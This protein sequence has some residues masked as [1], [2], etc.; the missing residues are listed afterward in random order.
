MQGMAA[1]QQIVGTDRLAQSA[2]GRSLLSV[3]GGSL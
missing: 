3:Q 1:D 2:Q